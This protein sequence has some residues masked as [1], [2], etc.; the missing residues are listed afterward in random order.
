MAAY[1]QTSRSQSAQGSLPP[2]ATH[3]T[4]NGIV[5][6]N[7]KAAL[8]R[9]NVGEDDNLIDWARWSW[10]PITGCEHNCPYCY[11]HDIAERFRGTTQ[12]FPNG[13][14]PTLHPGRLSAPLNRMPPP[15]DDP[16]DR[17]IF[18][19]SMADLF[20]RW[21]PE[22]WIEAVLQ[23]IRQAPAWTFLM[24]TKFPKR[25]AEFEIP[26]NVWM[27][28]TVDLQARVENAEKAFEHVRAG[29]KWLS[30]EPLLE[31]LQFSHL[32][33]FNW[34]VIGGASKSSKTPERKPNPE[35]IADLRRHADAA[36]VP[37]YEKS[38]L[39]RKEEPGGPRYNATDQLPDVFR[40]LGRDAAAD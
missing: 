12:F 17:R 33:R 38:N 39:L 21:V 11:A 32:D 24:L 16:R 15:S 36:K 6:R 35:W 14:E 29:V 27:G 34:M 8:N 22:E 10:N 20:G 37:V 25:M 31:S 4:D 9:E 23:V 28:T 2:S 5:P 19:C 13:F 7:P 3:S 18:V 1:S 30:L 26:K 40:Y